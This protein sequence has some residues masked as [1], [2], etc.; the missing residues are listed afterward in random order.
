MPAFLIPVVIYQVVCAFIG[1]RMGVARQSPVLGAMLGY[2][3]GVIGLLIL[4]FVKRRPT[5]PGRRAF[6]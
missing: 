4:L 6:A 5:T 1:Y 3:L 2:F